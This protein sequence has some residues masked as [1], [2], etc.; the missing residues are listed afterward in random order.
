[1]VIILIINEHNQF[2][3]NIIVLLMLYI[4]L[5]AASQFDIGSQFGS[6]T[7]HSLIDT[8]DAYRFFLYGFLF[9]FTLIMNSSLMITLV[10]LE[11]MTIPRLYCSRLSQT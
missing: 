1:M 8:H 3:E 9:S 4:T 11:R 2:E 10:Y 5:N 7:I 6:N